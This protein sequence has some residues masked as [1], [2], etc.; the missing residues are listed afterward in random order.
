MT[1]TTKQIG[2]KVLL[3]AMLFLLA[4]PVAPSPLGAIEPLWAEAADLR[5][6]KSYA[7][8]VEIYEQIAILSPHDPEPL[9]AIGDIYLT[10]QRWPLAED[11]F[12]RAL[13]RDG[14]NTQALAGLAAARWEQE[15]HPQAIEL[16]EHAVVKSQEP[17]PPGARVRL[18]LAYLDVGRL[19]DA[20]AM[21]RQELSH[22][23]SPVTRLY[24]AMMQAT[25]DPEAAQ[26]ELEAIADDEQPETTAARDYLLA[27]LDKAKAA[28][29][30]AE[31]TKSLGL[32]FIQ[33]EEWQL[34]RIALENALRL[35]PEDVESAAFLGHA[36]SQLGIPAFAHLAQAAN[37]QPDWP[38]GHYLLGLYYSKQEAYEFATEEF[39]TTL[40][41][42]PGNA[43]AQVD[44]ARA[45]L[46]QGLY[47]EAEEALRE[48]VEFAPD[49]LTFHLTLVQFYAD[50]AFRITDRGLAAAQAATDLAPQ[51]PQAR[52]M[53]GWMHFLAG[54]PAKA[55]LQL[56]T[57]LHIDPE[58]ASAY[59]HLGILLKT[60]NEEEAAQF[61]FL[62]AIDLDTKG[63][64][65]SQAQKALGQM[66]QA[67]GSVPY[68]R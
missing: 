39:Q 18:A 35:A 26:Q 55:R 40:R 51:N 3:V 15:D 4:M 6:Q 37:S 44:L 28:D 13:T 58:M 29:S 19:S 20:E 62:R 25:D 8:A 59:Y 34:A 11:A 66:V 53:L 12:N 22:S 56:E 41:L 5:T 54:D 48:A 36:E 43:Q 31:T 60:L 50:H 47:P 46:A 68:F 2:N 57:A 65:R 14:E 61:A 1:R 24:L 63:F 67:K 64:Y 32:A 52:D 9:R 45:Y 17:A 27:A 7:A 10:Q 38:L 30:E 23:G 42:D 33:I 49:D 16:W 21:L